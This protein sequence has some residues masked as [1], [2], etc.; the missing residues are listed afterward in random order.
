MIPVEL[1]TELYELLCNSF[2]IKLSMDCKKFDTDPVKLVAKLQPFQNRIFEPKDKILLVHMDTDYY[3]PLLPCGL[4]PI[5]IVRTFK[6]LD[7]PLHALLFV[8]NH[9]GISKEFD[10]LLNNQH[11]NDRPT[12]IQTLLTP[13]LLPEKIS[14]IELLPFDE[15]EKSAVCLMGRARSHRIAFYNFIIKHNLFDKI[16]VSQN[17]YV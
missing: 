1:H 9:I 12:I 7:I 13:L 5:N 8:T 4:I 6:N 16:A 3:D 2:N 10:Y 11:P 14:D 17:F 15:V